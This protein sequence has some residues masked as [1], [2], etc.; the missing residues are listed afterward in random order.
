MGSMSA[1]TGPRKIGPRGDVRL[2][3]IDLVGSMINTGVEP[4]VRVRPEAEIAAAPALLEVPGPVLRKP[5]SILPPMTTALP[6]SGLPPRVLKRVVPST[7][8][9]PALTRVPPEE[10]GQVTPEGRFG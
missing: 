5:P 8:T 1:V 7:D 4:P 10:E 3:V 2:P 9:V 6:A